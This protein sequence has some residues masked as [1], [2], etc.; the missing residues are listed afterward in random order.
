MASGFVFCPVG[1][2]IHFL[3]FVHGHISRQINTLRMQSLN[4]NI[5]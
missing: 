3:M 5:K 1:F 2:V 4:S